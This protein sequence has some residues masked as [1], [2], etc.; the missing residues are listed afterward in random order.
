MSDP[1]RVSESSSLQVWICPIQKISRMSI[2]SNP[3]FSFFVFFLHQAVDV[4]GNDLAN[5]YYGISPYVLLSKP[6]VLL[7]IPPSPEKS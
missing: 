7:A 6:R 5:K 3:E 4:I 2:V 1:I